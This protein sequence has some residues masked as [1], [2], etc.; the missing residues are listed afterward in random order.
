MPEIETSEADGISR[1]TADDMIRT[2]EIAIALNNHYAACRT[3]GVT[4]DVRGVVAP[5]V[6]AH[7]IASATAATSAE[8]ERIVNIL[9]ARAL[10]YRASSSWSACFGMEETIKEITAFAIAAPG[11][12]ATG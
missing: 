9:R 11:E 1:I 3:S 5:I 8:R 6:A 12:E 2:G 4:F 7:R 10:E